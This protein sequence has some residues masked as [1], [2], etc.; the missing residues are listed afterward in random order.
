MRPSSVE[1]PPRVSSSSEADS[2][3]GL[4][5]GEPRR[6]RDLR[7]AAA[8]ALESQTAHSVI[9]VLVI[10]DLIIVLLE[11]A[12]S[13]YNLD[14]EIEHLLW[15][16]ILKGISWAILAV[17]IVE[18]IA[19][20][21]VFGWSYYLLGKDGWVHSLDALIIWVSLIVEVCL[22]GRERELASLLIVLRLWRIVRIMDGVALSVK[23]SAERDVHRL[24]GELA[25]LKHDMN[26]LR[27][28]NT[29]LARE[30][31][32]YKAKAPSSQSFT[33]A[34]TITMLTPTTNPATT[35]KASHPY[36][37]SSSSGALPELVRSPAGLSSPKST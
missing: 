14:H 12:F 34:S 31:Q 8:Q 7:H 26:Q 21:L 23:M 15:F 1:P 17:F 6:P 33:P 11:I 19:K 18:C 35:T 32:V 2:E 37:T 5:A 28:S 30:L 36:M 20:L 13:L 10:T 9:L 24:E 3:A 22:H 25:A 4:V 29:R 16:Q 27:A